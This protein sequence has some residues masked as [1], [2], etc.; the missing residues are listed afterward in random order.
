[1]KKII[2]LPV[3]AIAIVLTMFLFS[4][5]KLSGKIT[6]TEVHSGDFQ[7]RRE[8]PATVDAQSHPLYFPGNIIELCCDIGDEIR[9]NQT[10]LY[11]S[12]IY[13]NR[14]KLIS[15]FNGII[16]AIESGRVTVK[17]QNLYIRCQVD[18]ETR[19]RLFIG[20]SHM[21]TAQDEHYRAYLQ[22]IPRLGFSVDNRLVF[23]LELSVEDNGKLLI[24]Q[25]GILTLDLGEDKGVLLVERQALLKD[26]RG[27]YLMDKGYLED[28]KHPQ[29]YRLPIELVS[30]NEQEA[31]IRGT[32]LDG[33]M[34]CV[35]SDDL[36][37]ILDAG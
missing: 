33:A 17:D 10:L 20:S 22:K 36:K 18:L 31:V 1:M 37:E 35:F 14:K 5:E 27:Y 19:N 6:I 7:Y 9:K 24:S 4:S 2:F 32:G 34:V 15:P 30:W 11:Y 12:D 26:G 21:F 25:P 29:H 8:V 28:P 16:T 3:L 13:G 23:E